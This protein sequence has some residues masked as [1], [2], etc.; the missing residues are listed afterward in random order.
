MEIFVLT[1]CTLRSSWNDFVAHILI[2]FFLLIKKLIKQFRGGSSGM[3]LQSY[4]HGL[5]V[6]IIAY[7][8]SIIIHSP[9]ASST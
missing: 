4:E 3:N 9:I 5:L 7:D 2:H 6:K 8:V 1:K